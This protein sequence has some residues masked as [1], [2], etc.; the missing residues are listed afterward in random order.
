M[1]SLTE[2]T[3]KA[4]ERLDIIFNNHCMVCGSRQQSS[5]EIVKQARITIKE[6]DLKDHIICKICAAKA[7]S[8]VT[9]YLKTNKSATAVPLKCFLCGKLHS[10]DLKS[11][12]L[13]LKSADNAFCLLI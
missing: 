1:N 7:K 9:Q 8:D 4:K 11:L 13:G 5:G 10:C 6:G 12:K 2:L 3:K